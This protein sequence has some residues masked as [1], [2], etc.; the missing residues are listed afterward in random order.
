MQQKI[1]IIKKNQ[2]EILKLKNTVNEMKKNAIESFNSSLSQEEENL[3]MWTQISWHFIQS[4]KK[5]EVRIKKS[6]ESLRE[7]WNAITVHIMEV[8]EEEEREKGTE[9]LL[10][11]IMAKTSQIWGE[12]WPSKYMK[13]KIPQTDKTQKDHHRDTYS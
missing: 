6:E 1:E 10:G 9:N 4:E 5:K 3:Q 2:R 11:E 12:I 8:P 7:L 13:L